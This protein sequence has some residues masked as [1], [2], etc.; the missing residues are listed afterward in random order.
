MDRHAVG[1]PEGTAMPAGV[2]QQTTGRE[3][4]RDARWF[5]LFLIPYVVIMTVLR[6]QF[7]VRY[8]D[9]TV[10][11]DFVTA[12]SRKTHEPDFWD[13]VWVRREAAACRQAIAIAPNYAYAHGALGQ[14]LLAAGRFA[15][16][17]D[18]TRRC[19]DL[20]PP[21]HPLRR[22]ATQQLQR[23]DRLLLLDGKRSAILKGKA[24]A[25]DAAECLG[26]A[27]VCTL[28][29]QH[30]AAAPF[31]ADAFAAE[32]KRADDLRTAHRYN[33]ACSAALAAAGQGEDAA[34]LA[35]KERARLRKQALE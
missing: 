21:G 1:K 35:D 24:K 14:A 11:G 32:P 8:S 33:A 19:L 25:K 17:R 6:G 13:G 9:T 30:A 15:E 29:R 12:T 10:L 22:F 34:G 31:Y 23:C 28:K 4:G 2:V 7:D 26:L 18:S 16:A 20:L 27:E 3:P 5:V